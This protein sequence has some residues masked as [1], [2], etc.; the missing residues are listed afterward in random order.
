MMRTQYKTIDSDHASN[1]GMEAVHAETSARCLDTSAIASEM[2]AENGNT[3]SQ[4]KKIFTVVD[5][6]SS[7]L[8]ARKAISELQRQGLRSS[9]IVVIAKNYQE[10]ENSI[11]WEYIAAD[12]GLLDVL[13]GLG[14]DMFAAAQFEDAVKNGKFLVA[15]IVTDHSASQAQYLLENIGH[16]VIS[17][18]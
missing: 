3:S 4:S 18:Y 5:I 8:E 13:A 14:L 1:L 12:S 17:V 7:R 10:H 6:F 9:Q 11:N 2:Y 15:A 16:R